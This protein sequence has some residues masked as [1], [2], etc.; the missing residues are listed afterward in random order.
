[1]H[2]QDD[3]CISWFQSTGSQ[4]FGLPAHVLAVTWP[5][6]VKW[7]EMY[8]FRL[9]LVSLALW[10]QDFFQMAVMPENKS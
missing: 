3:P 10:E 4:S 2:D 1:M 8:Q 5:Y 7:H 9:R 6:P